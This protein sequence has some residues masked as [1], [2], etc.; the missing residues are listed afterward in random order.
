M[1]FT[2][3]FCDFGQNT[4]PWFTSVFSADLNGWKES[5]KEG[6]YVYLWLIHFAIWQETN[7]TL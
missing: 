4:E 6:M 3:S 2:I 5:K 1:Y 7:A